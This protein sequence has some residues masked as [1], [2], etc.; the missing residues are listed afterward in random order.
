MWWQC[1]V[2]ERYICMKAMSKQLDS[3]GKTW[4][5]TDLMCNYDVDY[6]F[7]FESRD[8]LLSFRECDE[9]M[10]DEYPILQAFNERDYVCLECLD[11]VNDAVKV[12]LKYAKLLRTNLYP[13]A[14]NDNDEE[15]R[16]DADGG[17]N[18]E[19]DTDDG[20]D[21][22]LD[23]SSD[24]DEQERQDD[25]D[26]KQDVEQ[27][28]DDQQ[29]DVKKIDPMKDDNVWKCC[30]VTELLRIYSDEN[31]TEDDFMERDDSLKRIDE[32]QLKPLL[33]LYGRYQS[34]LCWAP[35]CDWI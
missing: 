24:N 32:A 7:D 18:D 5:P 25:D 4:I 11:G 14:S 34:V 3:D 35:V 33:D 13:K 19:E 10:S 27:K 20:D 30:S 21:D 26:V 29:Q 23:S 2:C 28:Q 8:E 6:L 16:Q 9:G 22:D 17:D 12:F 15:E 1:D 31:L